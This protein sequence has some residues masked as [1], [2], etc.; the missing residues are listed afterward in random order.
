M[1]IQKDHKE[2]MKQ[3]SAVRDCVK[4]SKK[5]KLY[6]FV[7]QV[8]KKPVSLFFKRSKVNRTIK[9]LYLSYLKH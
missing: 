9:P 7:N 5:A 6:Q 1:K 3:A 8:R 2:L 4:I